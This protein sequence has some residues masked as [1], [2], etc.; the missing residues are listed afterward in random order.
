MS[1]VKFPIN[2]VLCTSLT[3]LIP[4]APVCWIRLR[5]SRIPSAFSIWTM[6][7]ATSTLR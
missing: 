3:M 1:L 7:G 4:S 6:P 5:S 2:R